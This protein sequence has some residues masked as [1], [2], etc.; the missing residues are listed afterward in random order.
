MMTALFWICWAI[1]LLLCAIA[2]VGK[3]FADSFHKSDAVPWLAIVLVACTIGGLLLQVVF[4]KPTWALLVA[5]L[6]LL[7]MLGLYV[8]EKMTGN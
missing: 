2:I 5:A 4:K 1:N 7:F 8:F 6:P 3:G